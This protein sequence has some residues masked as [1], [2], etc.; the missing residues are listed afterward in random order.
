MRV[1]GEGRT[2][3]EYVGEGEDKVNSRAWVY[4]YLSGGR[5]RLRAMVVLKVYLHDVWF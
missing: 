1:R 2:G 4:A 3:G 5:V